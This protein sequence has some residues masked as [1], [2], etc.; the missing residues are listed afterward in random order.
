MRPKGWR[1]QL[2][3]NL[4]V[5][6]SV[7]AQ[8]LVLE[9]ITSVK[10][11]YQSPKHRVPVTAKIFH[12]FPAWEI[13]EIADTISQGREEIWLS[14]P[15]R[16]TQEAYIFLQNVELQLLMIPG[17]TVYIYLSGPLESP[18]IEFGGK[19]KD[20]QEYYVARSARFPIRVDQLVINLG[21]ASANLK[22]FKAQADSL[23]LL[24]QQFWSTYNQ[25]QHLPE[26]FIRHETD[27]IRYRNAYLRLYTFTYQTIVQQ[28]QGEIPAN[29]FEFLTTT[30][31]RNE[32]A[33]YDDYY[34]RFLREYLRNKARGGTATFDQDEEF[35]L[36]KEI[37]GDKI[38]N[39][40]VLYSISSYLISN[41]GKVKA[42]LTTQT[43][44]A[45]RMDLVD[46]LLV[47]SEGYINKLGLGD[48][49]PEFYL[50]DQLDSL[51]SLSQFKN[52]VV[53]LSFWFP[54]CKG[55]IQEFPFENSL[56]EKFRG[57]PVKIINICTRSSISKWMET[58]KKYDLKT[59]NLYANTSW[60]NKL[61]EKYGIQVYPH[62]VL[63]GAD[64][65]VLENFAPRPREIS[66][67]IEKALEDFKNN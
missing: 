28:K 53:Y 5:L 47:R 39:F 62:Y 15:I 27:A 55:C 3:I 52:H 36:A 67:Q 25:R 59:L 46:F 58:I 20:I 13:S 45:S 10:I 40:Y 61:E 14:C 11:S 29:F 44:P 60:Q 38:G 1:L 7:S 4:L 34:L 32:A 49:A 26:W 51:I 33:M 12:T 30:P 24:D 43:F 35:R 23:Y 56:V 64:G 9:G 63:I 21:L 54:G 6:T 22:T 19:T 16:T 65:R 66:K 42:D 50:Q 8:Q 2:A 57:E 18:N 37:L 48:E 41:P 31:I 17:D